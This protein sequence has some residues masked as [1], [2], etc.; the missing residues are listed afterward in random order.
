VRGYF[1]AGRG[2]SR[3]QMAFRG[4]EGVVRGRE[5]HFAMVRGVSRPGLAFRTGE[6]RFRGRKG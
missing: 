4:G 3:P 1:E 5:G 6:G 2:V